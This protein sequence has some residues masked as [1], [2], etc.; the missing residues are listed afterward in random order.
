LLTTVC[1]FQPEGL[2]TGLRRREHAS[3]LLSP[4]PAH[5]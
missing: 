5:L 3:V 4:F 2:L 1:Y